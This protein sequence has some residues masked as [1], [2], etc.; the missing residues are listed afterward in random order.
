VATPKSNNRAKERKSPL[1]PRRG[2]ATVN[3]DQ[4]PKNKIFIFLE[5]WPTPFGIYKHIVKSKM[6]ENNFRA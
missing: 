5:Y 6:Q 3:K 2:R 1:T 4:L